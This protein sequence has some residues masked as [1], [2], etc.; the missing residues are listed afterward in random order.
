M[1][2]VPPFAQRVARRLRTLRLGARYI[3]LRRRAQRRLHT[4]TV[5]NDSGR[6]AQDW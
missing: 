5:S 2:R 3:E 4:T 6:R 1:S